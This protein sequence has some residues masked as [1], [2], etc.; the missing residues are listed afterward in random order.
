[1]L[2]NCKNTTDGDGYWDASHSVNGGDIQTVAYR[3]TIRNDRE[4]YH[5]ITMMKVKS[6][7]S[8]VLPIKRNN[9]N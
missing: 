8:F 3:P 9:V 2:T 5:S 1:M 6:L 4:I 7:L